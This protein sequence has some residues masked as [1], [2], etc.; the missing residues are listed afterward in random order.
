MAVSAKQDRFRQIHLL[1]VLPPLFWAGN[2]LVARMFNEVIPPFQMS[3]WR[4]F[5]A[6]LIILPFT[7]RAVL[8]NMPAIRRELAY[9]AFLGAIGIT[10]FNCLIYLALQYTTVVN[11]ALINSLMP[12]V[13]FILALFFMGDRLRMRQTFGVVVCIIGTLLIIARGDLAV[14][15]A[16]DINAGDF[17]VLAGLTF[18]ALYT[19]MIRWR[20]SALPPMVF[21][22]V[23]IG[24]GVLFH[25][26]LVG[27]E[28]A[29]R[30]GPAAE[31]TNLLALLYLAIFPS[32]LAYIFWN[33]TVSALGPG[34]TGLFMYLMPIFSTLLAVLLLGEEFKIFHLIGMTLI[35]IGIALVTRPLI[36]PVPVQ[37]AG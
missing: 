17:L 4:W 10:A 7:V 23:T 24:F 30:G 11:A 2:F 25:F 20:K 22:T 8:E 35:V 32:L 14:L 1:A 15:L 6:L 27:W 37:S 16:L 18:W 21:L 5:I 34:K 13:T 3:F 12:V 33:R 9:L 26:P 29:T 28:F 19:V 36:Q 31:P